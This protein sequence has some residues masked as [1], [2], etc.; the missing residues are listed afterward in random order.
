MS[1]KVFLDTSILLYCFDAA[2]FRKQELARKLTALR[3]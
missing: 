1:G 3:L 2:D